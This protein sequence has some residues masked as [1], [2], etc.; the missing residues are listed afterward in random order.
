MTRQRMLDHAAHWIDAWN[1]RDVDAVLRPFA[2]DACFVS[3]RAAGIVGTAVLEGKAAIGDYWRRALER[4]GSLEF[5][6]GHVT[7]DVERREMVVFCEAVLG[8]ATATRACE[9]MRFDAEGR[10]VAGEALYGAPID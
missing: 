10:Q 8:G 1:R 6:P 2:E 3:P 7:C 9:L 5:R 4:I